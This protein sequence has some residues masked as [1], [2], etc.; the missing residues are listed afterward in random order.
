MDGSLSGLCDMFDLSTNLKT[1][2][3]K[4]LGIM[5]AGTAINAAGVFFLASFRRNDIDND[6]CDITGFW[7]HQYNN[8]FEEREHEKIGLP[9][10]QR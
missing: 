3:K 7:S 9:T 5:L 8:P 10:N 1:T 2:S 6:Q 4:T